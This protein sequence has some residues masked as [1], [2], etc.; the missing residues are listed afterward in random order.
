[1]KKDSSEQYLKYLGALALT[2]A[3]PASAQ[4]ETAPASSNETAQE[5]QAQASQNLQTLT[6]SMVAASIPS[7]G[8]CGMSWPESTYVRRVISLPPTTSSVERQASADASLS[9][10][11]D[12]VS[13]KLV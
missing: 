10:L 4:P 3:T 1:M 6:D 12:E 7:T 5:V 9:Q 11:M 8:G 13:K 2:V